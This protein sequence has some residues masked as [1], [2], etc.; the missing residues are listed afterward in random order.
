MILIIIDVKRQQTLD[1]LREVSKALVLDVNNGITEIFYNQ[2]VL[3]NESK[4]LNA[5]TT[6][7]S[8]QANGWTQLFNQL[9]TAVKELGDIENWSSHIHQDVSQ[10]VRQVDFVL[11]AKQKI[12]E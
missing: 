8:K 7:F 4:K 10:V 9:N 1:S 11:S 5:L 2:Q 6:K 12:G 3:E